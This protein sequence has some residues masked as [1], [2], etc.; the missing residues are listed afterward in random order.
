MSVNVNG[1]KIYEEEEMLQID[2]EDYASEIEQ[3]IDSETEVH[4]SESV[5]S[6][7]ISGIEKLIKITPHH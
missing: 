4:L 5:G 2:S 6:I 3:N 1:D 7:T